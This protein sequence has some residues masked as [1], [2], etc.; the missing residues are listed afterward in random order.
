MLFK[1]FYRTCRPDWTLKP[2][3]CCCTHKKPNTLQWELWKSCLARRSICTYPWWF[4]HCE[5]R[6]LP[7]MWKDDHAPSLNFFPGTRHFLH[8]NWP[9][10]SREIRHTFGQLDPMEDSLAHWCRF[11]GRHHAKRRSDL[12]CFAE[13]SACFR[14][15]ALPK[16]P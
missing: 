13:S 10:L 12:S 11:A 1:L 9:L 8:P 14:W 15:A 7:A 3:A 5:T 16:G 6:S 4:S 2:F